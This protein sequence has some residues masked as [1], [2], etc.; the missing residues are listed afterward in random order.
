MGNVLLALAGGSNDALSWRLNGG[1]ALGVCGGQRKGLV[2]DDRAGWGGGG[3][4]SRVGELPLTSSLGGELG[5]SQLGVGRRLSL[6]VNVGRV[7]WCSSQLV[8]GND[9][10]E[11]VC[12]RNIINATISSILASQGVETC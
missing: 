8:C 5:A 6:P 4:R 7:L 12:I 2:E 11:A 10:P 1:L 9:S 3:E